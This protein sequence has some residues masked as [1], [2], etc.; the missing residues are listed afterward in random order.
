M[1]IFISIKLKK[2][3]EQERDYKWKKPKQCPRCGGC[4]LWGHGYAPV[5]FDGFRKPLLIKRNRCPDCHC[6]IRFRPKGYFGRIQASKNAIRSCISGKL[7]YAKCP[8]SISRSRR[9][10]WVMALT[11]RI[12]AHFGDTWQKSILKGLNYL[13]FLGHIPVSRSI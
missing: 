9:R 12:K 13:A 3:F 2:L 5:L 6:V 10:H 11:R 8:G 7:K 4:R 1:V